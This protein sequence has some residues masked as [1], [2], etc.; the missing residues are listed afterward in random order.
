VLLGFRRERRGD[1]SEKQNAAEHGMGVRGMESAA[2]RGEQGEWRVCVGAG[3]AS[4]AHSRR[5]EC[6]SFFWVSH[7]WHSCWERAAAL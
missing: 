1:E 6:R 5:E 3:A 4:S 2:A 7:Y